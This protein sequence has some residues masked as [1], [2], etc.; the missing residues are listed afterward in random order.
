MNVPD[1][2]NPPA[3]TGLAEAGLVLEGW[4]PPESAFEPLRRE[5]CDYLAATRGET[6]AQAASVEQIE[7]VFVVQTLMVFLGQT[8][9]VST[10]SS[11]DGESAVSK[12]A[13]T[14]VAEARI[15]R[16]WQSGLQGNAVA[17]DMAAVVAT[18]G[19]E[20]WAPVRWLV[21]RTLV[22]AGQR[23]ELGT[24]LEK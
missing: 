7:A 11:S 8:C 19:R 21:Y 23:W 13:T 15:C 22:A 3:S 6:S 2:M 12:T 24:L 4:R 10:G 1:G 17:S 14:G 18:A 16:L 20:L 9:D 5:Y